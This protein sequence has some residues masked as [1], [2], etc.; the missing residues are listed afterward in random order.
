[1]H[2]CFIP[3]LSVHRWLVGKAAVFA[4]LGLLALDGGLY[5]TSA[6]ALSGVTITPSPIAFTG[7]VG[8]GPLTLPVTFKNSGTSSVS[9]TWTDSIPWIKAGYP[10]GTLSP[11]QSVTYNMTAN[12]S[13]MAAGS[14]SGTGSVTAGGVTTQVPVTLTLTAVTSTPAIGLNLTTLSF[15]GTAGGGTLAAKTFSISN[16]GG[17]TLS[18]TVSDNTA[19]LTLSPVSGTNTGSVSA[20]V[21]LSGLAAG[22]YNGTVSIAA[23]GATTK[24]LP[25]TLTVANASSTSGVTV[26]PSPIAFTGRVGPG[27]LTLPVTFKNS[28]TSSV[29]F[30]WTDSIPWIKAPC[31]PNSQSHTT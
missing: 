7:T 20:T 22:T 10:A 13:G 8:P 17:G 4:L 27:P 24:T 5:V 29:S 18:W 26:T 14:Y 1:M 21:N 25:V 30:T 6:L 12:I 19:W 9:F 28:G 15:T 16:M 11:G 23:T 3:F 31:R 2:P